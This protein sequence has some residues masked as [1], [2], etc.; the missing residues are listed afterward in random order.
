MPSPVCTV[1]GA[2]TIGGVNLA[3]GAAITVALVDLTATSWSLT[4]SGTDEFGSLIAVN[5][6]I[7]I[8]AATKT[9]TITGG[10]P[11][12]GSAWLL[13]STVN[14]GVD[15]NGAAQ[16]AYSTT[17]TIYVLTSGTLRRVVSLNE[18][19]EGNAVA[20]WIAQLNTSIRA[21]GTSAPVGAAGGDLG[22]TYPNPSVIG[23]G[24][25][26]ASAAIH[27]IAL[28]GDAGLASFT[29][30]QADNTTA[31][32]TA[33]AWTI[34]APNATGVTST[35]GSLTLATGTGT[36]AAGAFS[37][38]IGATARL[39]IAATGAITLSVLGA[40]F[41]RSSAGGLLASSPIVAAD[42]PSLVG[43]AAGPVSAT[44]V[45]AIKGITAP[46]GAP[47]AGQFMVAS[48]ASALA[49]RVL[50]AA[51]IPAGSTITMAGDVTGT[52]SASVVA[53]INGT[54][55]PA[56]P[57]AGQ[58]LVATNG[59]TASWRALLAGDVPA[60]SSITM[61]GDVVG[62]SGANTIALISAAVGNLTWAAATA[63]PTITQT[64]LGGAGAAASTTLSII[65]QQGQTQTG[66][67]VNNTGG[68][69]YLA[70]GLNG[71]GGG[72]GAGVTSAIRF[73]GELA[74]AR[75]PIGTFS[76]ANNQWTMIADT[77][78][79]GWTLNAPAAG[80]FFQFQAIG[81][82]ASA[83]YF[84]SPTIYWRDIS[85]ATAMTITLA[86]GGVTSLV[87]SATT[88]LKIS[89]GTAAGAYLQFI[90]PTVGGG[91]YADGTTLFI[92]DYTSAP[93]AQFNNLSS[94]VSSFQ[95]ASTTTYTIYQAQL[96]GTGTTA[97]LAIAIQAQQGQNQTGAAANTNGGDLQFKTGAA[98]TG[99]AGA[100]GVAGSIHFYSGAL[101]V[102]RD[103]LA[104]GYWLMQPD[105]TNTVGVSV[106]ASNMTGGQV[107]LTGGATSGYVQLAGKSVYINAATVYVRDQTPATC[108]TWALANA[109]ATSMTVASTVTAFLLTQ[110]TPTTDVAPNAMTIQAQTAWASAVTNLLGAPLN[111]SSGYNAD[112][113][114]R[115][116]LSVQSSSIA[117]TAS[118]TTVAVWS[119][120]AL[121]SYV[122][123]A[124]ANG[125]APNLDTIT[126]AVSANATL[127]AA[128]YNRGTINF[129][130]TAGGTIITITMPLQSGASWY[131][132][133][134]NANASMI[135]AGTTGTG[136]TIPASKSGVIWSDGTNIYGGYLG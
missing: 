127:T 74:G 9:A 115:S 130:N 123:L 54:S 13:T 65:A 68:T 73:A 108:I 97:G 86:S 19:L 120:T 61:A 30:K 75:V 37:I 1:N 131:V 71:T 42:L 62:T 88:G 114:T 89:A 113:V 94:G 18:S 87:C 52:T 59:T 34:Q 45:G 2:S 100:A 135:F 128:Q 63:T 81:S 3:A 17:F 93:V 106:D 23:I 12:T 122:K 10:A 4:C 60:S 5:A 129:T 98:G 109:G 50:S 132:R 21:A 43:D 36:T 105:A 48:S 133:N 7:V 82:A 112:G 117:V 101:H 38:N 58:L 22:G 79:S 44:I 96:A 77:G 76:A 83:M 95:V 49:Y 24:N 40:G 126:I 124:W 69:L 134:S 46:V 103:Y 29:L 102:G 6:S 56:T 28:V 84:T 55:V 35:G 25:G 31:S 118:S 32:A 111:L 121:T 92:R 39:A 72:G 119:S 64:Q 33:A 99:G 51:D 16:A 91:I 70:S 26:V 15:V 110:A 116:I 53:K 41:V 47:V 27:T 78:L 57:T 66:A 80:Q 11:A 125:V 85:S 136:V 104:S 14:A 20:G 67:T 107:L 90:A 8:N